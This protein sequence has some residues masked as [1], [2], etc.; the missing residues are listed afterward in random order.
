MRRL[1]KRHGRARLA[2]VWVVRD[3]TSESTLADILL[4]I[5]PSSAELENYMRG[6]AHGDWAKERHDMYLSKAEATRE[7]KR[8]LAHR[9][10]RVPYTEASEYR[11]RT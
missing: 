2:R 11:G 4:S 1:R 3:P 7:A 10:P 6:G 5:D 8:R 9:G